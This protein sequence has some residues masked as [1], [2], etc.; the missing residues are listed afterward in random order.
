LG[1]SQNGS[2]HDEQFD[3]QWVMLPVLYLIVVAEKL[4]DGWR[5][6]V[7]FAS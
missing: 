6:L 5:W 2:R 7:A 4:I 3:N 1:Y